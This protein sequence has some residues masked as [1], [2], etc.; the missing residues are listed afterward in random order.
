MNEGKRGLREGRRSARRGSAHDI[1][2]K[3]KGDRDDFQF[4]EDWNHRHAQRRRKDRRASSRAERANMRSVTVRIRI[5]T[6]V[7]LTRE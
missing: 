3:L 5:S 1:C 4:I 2:G 6:Q 7:E